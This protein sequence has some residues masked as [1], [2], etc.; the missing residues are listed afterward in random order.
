MRPLLILIATIAVFV[1]VG[2][3]YRTQLHLPLAQRSPSAVLRGGLVATPAEAQSWLETSAGQGIRRARCS[4]SPVH[5]PTPPDVQSY[6]VTGKPSYA[7]FDCEAKPFD[8]LHPVH[9]WCV[10]AMRYQ[11]PSYPDQVVWGAGYATCR[12]IAR[13]DA[14]RF[15]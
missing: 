3:Q 9:A 13:K 5:L 4:V 7:A 14:Q 6:V 8:A 15:G 10:F 11:N 1:A 2:W 12:A